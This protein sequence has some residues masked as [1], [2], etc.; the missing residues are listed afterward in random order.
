MLT[1]GPIGTVI[2][3]LALAVAPSL[4]VTVK[5]KVTIWVA[6]VVPGAVQVASS[7]AGSPNVPAVAVHAYVSTSV[8]MAASINR[9]APPRTTVWSGVSMLTVGSVPRTGDHDTVTDVIIGF[10]AVGRCQGQ[11]DHLVCRCI[12]RRP[13]RVLYLPR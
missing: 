11:G 1:V 7:A 2:V 3:I 8:D 13:G 10:A 12:R 9:A 4:S 5:V 6:A